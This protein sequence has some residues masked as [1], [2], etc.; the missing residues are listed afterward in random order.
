LGYCTLYEK[1][2]TLN[3]KIIIKERKNNKTTYIKSLNGRT[4]PFILISEENYKRYF[5][6][7][8]ILFLY[9]FL[10]YYHLKKN[11]KKIAII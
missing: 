11:K 4:Y 7:I 2:T 5:S 3:N 6:L 8:E 9:S 10:N 1:K